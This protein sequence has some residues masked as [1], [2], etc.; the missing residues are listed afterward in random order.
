M[1]IVMPGKPPNKDNLV[2]LKPV[3]CNN[4]LVKASAYNQE[5]ICV[6]AFNLYSEDTYVQ[7]FFSQE[8]A[9][10]FVTRLAGDIE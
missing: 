4:W 1:I 8:D 3:L 6:V 7:Y 2:S 10:D 5:V 9:A